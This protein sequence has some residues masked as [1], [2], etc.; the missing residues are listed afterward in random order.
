MRAVWSFVCA[1]G[2]AGIN[3]QPFLFE[4]ITAANGLAGDEVFCLLED[5]DGFIWAGT[6]TGLSRLEGTRIRNFF[7]DPNDSTSLGHD[8]V[9]GLAQDANGRIWCA[10]MNGLS[11]FDPL[12]GSFRTYR[13]AAAGSKAV[14][15]NRMRQVVAI[16]DSL[17]WVVT[18]D[19]LHR[20]DVRNSTWSYAQGQPPGKGPAGHCHSRNALYWDDKRQALWAATDDGLSA[21]DARSDAW[22]DHRNP[23]LPGPWTVRGEVT[24][25]LAQ[26]DTLWFHAD[27]GF[28]LMAFP[29]S[30]G[31]L[32]AELPIA[33]DDNRFNLQWQAFDA[34][35]GHWLSTWTK[36][37][38]HRERGGAWVELTA[39]EGEP[40]ALPTA[41]S[42]NHL[43]L[44]D[45]SLAIATTRGIAIT[46]TGR[47]ATTVM[48]WR[49]PGAQVLDLLPIGSDSLIVASTSGVWLTRPGHPGSQPLPIPLAVPGGAIDAASNHAHHLL[50]ST[51][52]RIVVS[53]GRGLRWIDPRTLRAAPDRRM[54]D[55]WPCMFTAE[56]EGAV[57]VG[58]W[59]S[60]LW[61]CPWDER[62]PCERVD[63]VD[64][65]YG[66]LPSRML[67]CWLTDRTGR[68]W[69]GMNNG[70]GAAVMEGGKWRGVKDARGGLLGGVVRCMAEAPDGSIWLGTHEQGIVVHDPSSGASRFITRRDGLPGARVLALRFA[71]DGCLWAVTDQGIARSPAGATA[72]TPFL[73]PAGLR[74]RGA[75]DAMAELA[76]G[77]LV[78]GVKDRLVLHDPRAPGNEERPLRAVITGH[79]VNDAPAFGPPGALVLQANR[80]ALSLELGAIGTL[81]GSSV[82]FRYRIVNLDSAWLGIGPSQRIDLFDLPP[83]Q[84]AIEISASRDGVHWGPA[85]RTAALRVLPPF[86]ATWWFRAGMLTLIALAAILGFRI[87]LAARLRQQR[88]AFER[89]Q[90]LL[91]E[92]VRI[93]DDMHDDLGAGLSGLKLRSE[94]ALRTE[95]DPARRAQLEA[96]A[97]GAGELIASMR[98]IIW[99]MSA[100]Q[101][102]VADLAAYASS[103]ARGYCEEH[104]LAIEVRSGPG[105]PEAA[106]T[107]E[108]RRNC[109]LVVKEALHNV[110]KH[111][112][113]QRV[114]LTIHWR[115]GLSITLEDDGLGL[116]QHAQDGSGNGLRS[117]QRRMAGA[118]GSI[119]QRNGDPARGELPGACIALHLPL[120]HH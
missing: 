69:V 100:D 22:S 80:K 75:A 61:R 119:V 72:F 87:Y 24:A 66:R 5:R 58:T 31:E 110:V 120:P 23:A 82:L 25:P 63:T 89:E 36:R 4:R 97:E 47:P 102:S 38:F 108:Q 106:L 55:S 105:M 112:H 44:R 54:R 114:R 56:A 107:S 11:R 104:G 57:W 111:A 85:L 37:L 117:M 33:L 116:P 49:F 118:G 17:A 81:P 8:Q 50:R 78:F 77:R 62:L 16:G 90:A 101:G 98:Q 96:M 53:T 103:Y 52:G 9:N 40:G 91:A 27:E 60:G 7:H 19:G 28:R 83:G 18:E 6:A 34:H 42:P 95:R 70:G 92:R 94:M 1:I 43:V 10:T 15:A 64:G 3:A 12:L 65:P 59:S 29:L 67:L 2:W 84:H 74:E 68:H 32:R 88:A 109:F 14:Q 41:S 35:G 86:Y 30:T 99:A 45:G 13:I 73:L 46:R 51:D 79:R 26:G 48:P 113:A 20:F 71:Q 93:A 39:A 115:E 21:W 76:D